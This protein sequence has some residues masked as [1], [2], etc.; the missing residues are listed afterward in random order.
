MGIINSD[1]VRQ[2]EK[3]S[4]LTK[5]ERALRLQSLLNARPDG[6]LWVFAFG[7]LM[8][9]PC[10]E[11]DRSEEVTFDG[12]ERKFHIW[13]TVSRGTKERPGLGLCLEKGQG[14]CKGIAYQLLPE[15]EPTDWPSIWHREMN[16]GIYNAI[17]VDLNLHTGERVKALTFVVD[18]THAQYAGEMPVP[19]MAEIIVGATGKYGRCRD[20]LA[21]T[22]EEMAKLG[23]V[24]A[25]LN[26]LLLAVDEQKEHGTD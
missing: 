2:P 5:D 21:S 9:N 19:L 6:P 14:V 10:F 11:Y 1:I 15:N 3:F 26:E 13:S 12:W 7:S 18:P 4:R 24:D 17:W 22:V 23:I 25:F 16:T 8:W 20:Y